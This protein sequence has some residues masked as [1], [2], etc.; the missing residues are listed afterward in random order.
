MR[1]LALGPVALLFAVSCFGQSGG[2]SQLGADFT[3]EAEHFRSTCSGFSFGNIASC[4]ELLFTDHPLHI[5][6][7]SLAPQNGFGLGGAFVGHSTTSNWRNTF[8]VDA[9]TSISGAWR[10][11]GYAN[12]VY[13][14][15]PEPKVGK[16]RHSQQSK[17]LAEAAT[18]EYPVIHLYAEATS[19]NKVGFYGIGLETPRS[20]QSWF[21]FR[22]IITGASAVKPFRGRLNLSISGEGN[23]RFVTTRSA[24]GYGAPSIE[25]RFNPV[26]A[27]GL[28]DDTG[29]AQFGEGIGIRPLLAGDHLELNYSVSFQQYVGFG[30]TGYAFQRLITDLSQNIPLHGKY[31]PPPVHREFNGPDECSESPSDREMKCP[32]VIPPPSPTQTNTGNI[33]LQFLMIDSYT[34]GANVVPFYFQPT[35]GGSDINGNP[36]LPSYPDYRFRAPNLM[37][38]R[39][40]FEHAIYHW[41]L[42]VTFRADFGKVG[43]HP[44]D[45]DFTGFHHSYAA[46]LTLR[47]GVSRWS[48][49][50]SR[51][52]ATKGITLSPR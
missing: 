39:G 16:G 13:S 28:F 26:S 48:I 38:L 32:P 49:Y 50:S 10:A 40:S 41:P 44:T 5:A 1:W 51:G 33:E 46:G 42:G 7:G 25:V 15:P 27:P 9:V 18:Q 23:G 3:K 14:N 37:L 47:A 11:G 21:G 31:A 43:L 45:L 20:L 19:L 4:A 52:A 22:E 35:L 36:L 17:Q 30:V 24:R 12:F 2:Q 8:D 6:A 34:S 29:F